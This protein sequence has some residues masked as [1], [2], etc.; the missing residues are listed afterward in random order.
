MTE[1]NQDRNKIV[2]ITT[3]EEIEGMRSVSGMLTRKL[4]VDADRLADNINIFLVQ[5]G[6]VMAKT[7]DAVGKFQL[8][9]VEVSAEI[10]GKGQVVLWGV[11]G[12]VGAGGGIKFVFK[13]GSL[14][15]T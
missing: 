15:A 13:K 1:K 14:P 4:E 5:M 11:G 2:I 8:A 12:E 3:E 7:P 6:E 9:E 10:T